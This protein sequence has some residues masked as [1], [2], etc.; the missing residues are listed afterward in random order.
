VSPATTRVTAVAVALAAGLGVSAFATD[1]VEPRAHPP[2]PVER[3]RE[4][5][6]APSL[7][8]LVYQ[9]LH[10]L[11]AATIALAI[12][13]GGRA[14]ALV[15]ARAAAVERVRGELR[16]ALERF[17]A[18]PTGTRAIPEAGVA[19]ADAVRRTAA[20]LRELRR[21]LAAQ[22]QHQPSPDP[23]YTTTGI[24]LHEGRLAD[25]I[26]RLRDDLAADE[27]VA[28]GSL[29]GVTARTAPAPQLASAELAAAREEL[30]R[31][32][33][34]RADAEVWLR[35]IEAGPQAPEREAARPDE[36]AGILAE[37]DRR[38]AA[39]EQNLYEA[40]ALD[41]TREQSPE[42]AAET[43]EWLD[44]HQ[45]LADREVAAIGRLV[46]RL[47]GVEGVTPDRLR[48]ALERAGARRTLAESHRL[49]LAEVTGR[50]T[51]AGAQDALAAVAAED[52]A[53]AARLASADQLLAGAARQVV[54]GPDQPEAPD[55]ARFDTAARLVAAGADL[56]APVDE[57]RFDELARLVTAAPAQPAASDDARFDELARIAAADATVPDDA[58]LDELAAR[59]AEQDA[60]AAG[61]DDQLPATPK[62]LSPLPGAGISLG[63]EAEQPA[64]EVDY[65]KQV[66]GGGE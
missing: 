51:G 31:A 65:W 20:K 21:Y 30:D 14:E 27:A 7:E 49:Q 33:A 23:V 54:A 43:L 19:P 46:E 39:A 45:R 28:R 4:L 13:E 59:I 2:T 58:R 11:Q 8:E 5:G 15:P 57:S 38:G 1:K 26:K 16:T 24:E 42:E 35:A 52:A 64:P 3:A 53:H 62:L 44:G 41:L 17:R 32:T 29:I 12:A 36:I 22:A 6:R 25:E 50:F 40:G 56:P 55:Q 66:L 9:A 47:Q 48:P 61:N 10:D 34:A 37:I 18:A 63:L 60:L